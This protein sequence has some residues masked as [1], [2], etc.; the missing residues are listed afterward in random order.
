M[1]A[2]FSCW[3]KAI[4]SIDG[5]GLAYRYKLDGKLMFRRRLSDSPSHLTD[6]Q[7]ADDSVLMASSDRLHNRFWMLSPALP[8]PLDFQST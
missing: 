5:V 1:W 4:Q 3:L 2:V 6:C 7:F 8:P